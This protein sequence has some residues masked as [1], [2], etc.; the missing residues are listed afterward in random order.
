MNTKSTL[1]VAWVV[2]VA[3]AYWFGSLQEGPRLEDDA[4]TL[5]QVID[6]QE[7]RFPHHSSEASSSP[8]L[9]F[10]A[11][12]PGIPAGE[13]NGNFELEREDSYARASSTGPLSERLQYA[14]D[15][16]E[17]MS[18][19]MDAFQRMDASNVEEVVA[20]F[21]ENTEPN[22]RFSELRLLIHAWA[23]FDPQGAVEWADKLGGW[24]ER[25]AISAALER[26]ALNDLDA[27]LAWAKEKFKGEDNPYLVGIIG[28]LSISDPARA[29]ELMVKMPYGRNR[30]RAAS[31]LLDAYWKEGEGEAT[32]WAVDMEDGSV[33]DY[34][35][36]QLAERIAR[37]DVGRSAEWVE[38][39][40][41]GRSKNRAVGMVAYQ[42]ARKDPAATAQW[43]DGL[44]E[45]DSRF[46]G[47]EGL[48]KVWVDKDAA[49]T[50]EWLNGYD[51]SEGKDG[52]VE[53]FVNAIKRKDPASA[54]QWAESMIDEE[55]REEAVEEVARIWRR[56]DPEAYQA[57]KES[58]SSAQE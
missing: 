13:L 1:G 15:P 40:S 8:S 49:A 51:P 50:A 31:M 19:L 7:P 33:K 22:R 41:D 17:R 54:M 55:E 27:S 20:A 32:A 56:G 45:T 52:A 16:M 43:I 38:S 12:E 14:T 28:G 53:I 37:E 3:I 58:R 9:S 46:S 23:E 35:T 4:S 42:W 10:S 36:S 48:V 39:L 6:G 57:W 44:G 24:E 30:G 25:S 29:T 26:W 5:G 47:M 21:K 11:E 34:V 18:V 2:S